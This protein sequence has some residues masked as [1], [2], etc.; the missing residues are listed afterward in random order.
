MQTRSQEKIGFIF[1]LALDKQQKASSELNASSGIPL[2][3]QS[4][5]M[6]E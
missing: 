2:D 5:P 1:Q 3:S 6:I 4:N